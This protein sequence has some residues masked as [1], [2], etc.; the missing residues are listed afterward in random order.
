MF[1][2]K[3]YN[4]V[5]ASDEVFPELIPNDEVKVNI[6][7]RR[8]S[9]LETSNTP[10]RWFMQWHLAGGELWLSCAKMDGGYLL[11]FNELADFFVNNCGAEI[12]CMSKPEIPQETVQHLLL[13]Q[14]IPLVINLKGN[15]ALHASAILT[16][17]GV[18][19]FA[20]QARSG[21]STVVG[22]FLKAGYSFMSD[23]CLTLLEKGRNIY[24]IPAYPGLRLWRDARVYLFE[25]NGAQKSVAHYT[26]KL[27]VDIERKP[28]TY[29]EEPQP[30]K[31]VYIIGDSSEAKGKTNIVIERLS[32]K[33]S[34][35]ELIKYTFRLDITDVNMLK[36]QF[37]FIEQVVSTVPV[38]R[39][40]YH[41]NFSLLPAV[42]EAILNDLGNPNN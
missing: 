14:V 39:L 4:L 15:E 35:I 5:I 16:P 23:D 13:D 18:V 3:L 8:A 28:E 29:C 38:N 26:D 27:R 40:T 25:N 34:F 32:F 1:Q 7:V 6:H 19:A 33:N 30:L 12:V 9:C 17:Q 22:S 41:R 36:R 21:K 42:R 37:N 10:S 2:Y 31:G 24:A 20:G 11:R